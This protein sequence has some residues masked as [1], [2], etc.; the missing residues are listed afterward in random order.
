MSR[1][2]ILKI[3]LKLSK[4]AAKSGYVEYYISRQDSKVKITVRN[5][6]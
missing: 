3:S 2:F 4:N 5:F 6:H 1:N